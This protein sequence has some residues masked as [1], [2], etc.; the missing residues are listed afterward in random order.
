MSLK[1]KIEV[2]FDNYSNRLLNEYVAPAVKQLETQ[3]AEVLHENS[4]LKDENKKLN[5]EL[6]EYKAIVSELRI[7]EICWKK[8]KPVADVTLSRGREPLEQLAKK[9]L[10]SK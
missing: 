7:Y 9:K 2:I 1:E 10:G 3:F 5:F 8:F 4:L 6:D